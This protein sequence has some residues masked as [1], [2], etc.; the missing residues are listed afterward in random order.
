[1]T[2]E[3]DANMLRAIPESSSLPLGTKQA[4][5]ALW[6]VPPIIAVVVVFV[7]FISA[8]KWTA[9]PKTSVYDYYGSLAA[10]LQQGTVSDD[11]PAPD[12]GSGS[13]PNPGRTRAFPLAMGCSPL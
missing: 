12:L 9:W 10:A 2:P 5:L 13:V 11:Q 8:G 3:Y 1:M 6:I 4:R 7:W